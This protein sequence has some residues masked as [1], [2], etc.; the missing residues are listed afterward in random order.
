MRHLVSLISSSVLLLHVHALYLQLGDVLPFVLHIGR[1]LSDKW[2]LRYSCS[3][4][5]FQIMSISILKVYNTYIE[6]FTDVRDLYIMTYKLSSD[7]KKD[8]FAL[9]VNIIK[10]YHAFLENNLIDLSN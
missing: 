8:F 4:F 5:D 6:E 3:G 2:F 7:Q 9:T 10:S 1:G